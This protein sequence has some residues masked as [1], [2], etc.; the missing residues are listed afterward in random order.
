MAV[1]LEVD[2]GMFF[3]DNG[4]RIV[5]LPLL[6]CAQFA[7][8]LLFLVH[9]VSTIRADPAI[10]KGLEHAVISPWHLT[11]RLWIVTAARTGR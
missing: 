4:A 5:C 8:H 9:L 10:A 2:S 6:K 7:K 1:Q 11:T 3:T